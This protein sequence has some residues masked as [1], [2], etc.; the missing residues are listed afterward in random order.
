MTSE[1]SI[2]FFMSPM[3]S[4]IFFILS[5]GSY[6]FLINKI[7]FFSFKGRI[8]RFDYWVIYFL[9]GGIILLF[10]FIAS[11]L[12]PLSLFIFGLVLVYL[13][14]LRIPIDVRRLHDRE[15]SAWYVLLLLI[16]ILGSIFLLL[17]LKKGTIGQNKYGNEQDVFEG[18]KILYA[19]LGGAPAINGYSYTY[20]NGWLHFDERVSSFDPY[21]FTH[22][23]K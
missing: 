20:R 13:R 5:F 1:S 12:K 8:S 2:S 16:P 22:F 15:L 14:A 10:Y 17:F 21:R 19:H 11:L 18:S 3:A 4:L 23:L 6:L 7:N 9:Y